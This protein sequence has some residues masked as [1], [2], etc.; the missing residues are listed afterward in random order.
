[1]CCL[2]LGVRNRDSVGERGGN[3]GFVGRGGCRLLG[4]RDG[5]GGKGRS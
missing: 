5:G 3:G 2:V 4:S 1:M